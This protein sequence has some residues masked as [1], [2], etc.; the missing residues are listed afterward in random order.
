[1]TDVT[2][3]DAKARLSELVGRVMQGDA[4]RITRRGK[5]VAQLAPVI[6]KR[7]PIDVAALRALTDSMPPQTEAEAEAAATT[8][9][10]M[11]DDARY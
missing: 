2:L 10:L 4:V 5:P 6:G 8:V 9:R 1:M 7:A 11:R 3:A